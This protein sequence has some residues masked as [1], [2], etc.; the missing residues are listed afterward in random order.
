MEFL[1]VREDAADAGG[2]LEAKGSGVAILSSFMVIYAVIMS[3]GLGTV[4]SGAA[5][6]TY[7]VI[8]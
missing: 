3:L 2:G 8:S 7:D 1:L 5:Y 6:Y 4:I